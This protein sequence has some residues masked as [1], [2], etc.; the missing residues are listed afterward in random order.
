MNKKLIKAEE[1]ILELLVERKTASMS[2]LL[3]ELGKRTEFGAA[4]VR[5]AFWTLASAGMVDAEGAS[6]TLRPEAAAA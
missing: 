4:E 2:D 5:A 1:A 6:I 3:E